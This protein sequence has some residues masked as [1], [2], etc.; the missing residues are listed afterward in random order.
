METLKDKFFNKFF[1]YEAYMI[2]NSEKEMDD[3]W[4][5]NYELE[6]G[7]KE[8]SRFNKKLLSTFN[9]YDFILGIEKNKDDE[10]Y[11]VACHTNDS[12]VDIDLVHSSYKQKPCIQSILHKNYSTGELHLE[13]TDVQPL[14]NSIGNGSILM[15]YFIKEAKRLNV[16]YIYGMLSERDRDNFCRSI[17]YYNKFGFDIKLNNEKT[18]GSVKLI[19]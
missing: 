10:T 4:H 5:K 8:Y 18:S 16:K 2:K 19:L 9:K 14:R 7:N 3:L 11:I 6:K 15:T 12:H 17:P 13:I 1:K